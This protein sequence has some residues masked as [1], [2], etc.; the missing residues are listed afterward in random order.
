[1]SSLTTAIGAGLLDPL[2]IESLQLPLAEGLFYHPKGSFS[3]TPSSDGNFERPPYRTM[4]SNELEADAII[5]Q[6]KVLIVR[7]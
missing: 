3:F 1:M 6:V 5:A 4:C 2:K 7:P